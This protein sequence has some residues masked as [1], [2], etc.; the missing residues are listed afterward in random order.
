MARHFGINKE[1]INYLNNNA[2]QDENKQFNYNKQKIIS[3]PDNE[4]SNKLA[5]NMISLE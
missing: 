2:D 5:L 1:K 3:L 4:R